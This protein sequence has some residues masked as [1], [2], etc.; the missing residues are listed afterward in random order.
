MKEAEAE[1]GR[2]GRREGGKE[3]ERE[4]AREGRL[5]GEPRASGSGV[6]RV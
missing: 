1:R 4:G 2:K 5:E 6:F 3:G